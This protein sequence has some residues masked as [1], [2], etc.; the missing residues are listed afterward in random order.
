M[1]VDAQYMSTKI[2]SKYQIY[3]DSLK[4]VEYNYLFPIWGQGAYKKGFDIPY[5]AGIM[6]NYMWMKQGILIDNLQLGLTTNTQDVPLTGVD[7][8]SFGENTNTSYTVNVRPDL[9]IF[10]FLNVYGI[11]GYGNSSTEVNIVAPIE[12]ST[13][14]D[15]NVSTAGV[16]LLS[17]FG[18][19]PVWMSVDFNM[20][21]NK[22]ELLDKAVNANVLGLRLGHTFVFEHKPYRNLAIWAGAMRMH[23]GSATAGEIQL[24]D[25]LPAQTWEQ[26][27]ELVDNY[28]TWY[29][30]EATLAQKLTADKILTPIV[31]RIESADGSSVVK[32]G[33]DKQVKNMWNGIVGMQFQLNKRWMFRGEGGVI[34]D[35]KSFLISV[36]YRFLV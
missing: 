3:T 27:D 35:R 6:G 2:K 16:G 18:I 25:A 26:R 28:W 1:Q 36:N 7:F 29:D 9:W 15:Q 33:M 11:F 20:T 8:I 22:P 14:V 32:Y 34:G 23:M 21:W 10:P 19:G 12:L 30:N 13:V 5:P 4:H 31:D 17:A 24:K